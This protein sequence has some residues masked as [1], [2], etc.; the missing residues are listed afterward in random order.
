MADKDVGSFWR[1]QAEA[2]S[3]RWLKSEHDGRF[4]LTTAPGGSYGEYD[5]DSFGLGRAET[6]HVFFS[7]MER[8]YFIRIDDLQRQLR[9]AERDARAVQG[10]RKEFEKL[11]NPTV[12]W[13]LFCRALVHKYGRKES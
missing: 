4:Y 10:L 12:A 9:R 3:R 7:E 2:S 11:R 13:K 6:T 5:P 1:K 8:D